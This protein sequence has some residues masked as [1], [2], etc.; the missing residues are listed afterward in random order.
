MIWR[1]SRGGILKRCRLVVWCLYG[2]AWR[3]CLWKWR[4]SS[5]VELLLCR[6]VMRF[7][8]R[9]MS[10]RDNLRHR[11]VD[12]NYLW[13]LIVVICDLD[14]ISHVIYTMRKSDLPV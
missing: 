11:L 12:Y 6:L 13:R 9:R 2:R 5:V 4:R 14:S 10:L 3:L 1:W 8:E 7:N